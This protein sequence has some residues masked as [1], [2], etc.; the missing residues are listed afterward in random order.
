MVPIELAESC[1]EPASF[2]R[3]R[4]DHL[5]DTGRVLPR[6]PLGDA[7]NAFQPIRLAP[8]QQSLERPDAWQIACS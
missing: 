2:F 8:Q 6:L 1:A 7:A 4:D 3:C 5:I